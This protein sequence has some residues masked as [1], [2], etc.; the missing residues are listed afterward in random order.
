MSPFRS[1]RP[2]CTDEMNSRG[3]Q[4]FTRSSISVA[5]KKNELLFLSKYHTHKKEKKHN[6]NTNHN[7]KCYLLI[8]NVYEE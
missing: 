2:S 4:I 7:L 3:K 5:L 6:S 1:I 8:L